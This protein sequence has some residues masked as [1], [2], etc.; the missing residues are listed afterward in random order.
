[1]ALAPSGNADRDRPS[2][3][4]D[5]YDSIRKSETRDAIRELLSVRENSI[6]N[7]EE[8]AGC[9][10]WFFRPNATRRG[11]TQTTCF[12]NVGSPES[13]DEIGAYL[14]SESPRALPEST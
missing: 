4:G 8:A 10:L 2:S 5:S 3:R 12:L 7:K 6:E 9:D 14:A 11:K 1:M 13:L